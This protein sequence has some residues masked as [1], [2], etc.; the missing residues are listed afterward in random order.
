MIPETLNE[1]NLI[2]IE[3]YESPPSLTYRLDF[4]NRRI[5]GKIDN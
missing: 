3:E 1:E 2:D 4:T 5:I